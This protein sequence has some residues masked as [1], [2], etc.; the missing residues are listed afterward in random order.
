MPVVGVNSGSTCS[1]PSPLVDNVGKHPVGFSWR[2]SLGHASPIEQLTCHMALK[3]FADEAPDVNLETAKVRHFKFKS[4][5]AL[6]VPLIPIT[7]L[8][9][10]SMDLELF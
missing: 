6:L 2:N 8:L 3:Y 5:Y 7:L 9:F 10:K 1:T 4:S